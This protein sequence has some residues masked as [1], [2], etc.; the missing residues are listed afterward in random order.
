MGQV[1]RGSLAAPAELHARPERSPS[2]PANRLGR[3]GGTRQGAYSINYVED[4]P[5]S[6]F[7]SPPESCVVRNRS[8]KA[9]Q[10]P[11][12]KCRAIGR[13]MVGTE[14]AARSTER[15]GDRLGRAACCPVSA[16]GGTRYTRG[17]PREQRTQHHDYFVVPLRS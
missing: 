10:T 5:G 2:R 7:Y 8:E 6:V 13:S 1:D 9:A 4:G 11:L 14:R 15:V 3:A 12:I 17:L 16:A